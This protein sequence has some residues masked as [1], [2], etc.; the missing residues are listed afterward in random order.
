MTTRCK[1]TVIPPGVSGLVGK[2]YLLTLRVKNA[3][4]LR[5]MRAAGF[6]T[7][8]ALAEAAGVG[9]G[10]VGHYLRLEMA[11]LARRDGVP[12]G[13]A[14]KIAAA[15]RCT[16]ES[17]FPVQHLDRP[18]K[19]GKWELEADIEDIEQLTDQLADQAP[20]QLDRIANKD[21]IRLIS[22][23]LSLLTPRERD[24]IEGRFGLAGRQEETLDELATKLGVGKERVRQIEAKALRKL[25]DGRLR[26]DGSAAPAT[27]LKQ[28]GSSLGVITDDVGP[29]DPLPN[30]AARS[31]AAKAAGL[32]LY[33]SPRMVESANVRMSAPEYNPP[34]GHGVT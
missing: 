13:S 12:F 25:R 24:V 1:I 5:A 6:T 3:P 26:T 9:Y 33:D 21:G 20:S 27:R 10:T 15:L 4:M 16:V 7:A 8:R 17:I 18:I 11:P 14:R 29:P 2:D 28:A 23:A 32:H 31:S 22:S 30:K 19:V 34:P